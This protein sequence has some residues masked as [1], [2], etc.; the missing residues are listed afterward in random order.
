MIRMCIFLMILSVQLMRTLADGCLKSEQL[1]CCCYIIVV[2]LHCFSCITGLL[3]HKLVILVTHQ[4]QY[5]R[6]ANS[7][8]V[9]REVSSTENNNSNVT[10]I[11]GS[12]TR[13]WFF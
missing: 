6:Q 10:V 9:I 5:A 8:L 11:L 7:V 3:R 4:L 1:M 12:G 13:F 2:M